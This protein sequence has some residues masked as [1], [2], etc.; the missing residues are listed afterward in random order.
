MQRAV[1]TGASWSA[2]SVGVTW[3]GCAAC[4]VRLALFRMEEGLGRLEMS[5]DLR[6]SDAERAVRGADLLPAAHRYP[7]DGV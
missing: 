2:T 5:R 3:R 4:A 1:G 6:C 7:V